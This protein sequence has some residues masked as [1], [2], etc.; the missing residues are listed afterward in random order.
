MIKKNFRRRKVLT[1]SVLVNVSHPLR[2]GIK[3]GLIA[4]VVDQD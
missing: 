3:G 4:D 2:E 1:S